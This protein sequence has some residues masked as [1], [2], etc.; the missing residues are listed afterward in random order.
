MIIQ[1]KRGSGLVEVVVVVSILTIVCLA[2][3]NSFIGLSGLHKK[4]TLLIKG[5][6]LTEEGVEIIRLVRD[7]GWVNISSIP[8]EQDRYFNLSLSAWG[9]TTTPE[10]ID[11]VFLRKFRLHE[12]RRVSANGAIVSSGGVVDTDTF[13]ADVSV[14]WLWNKA[15]TTLKYQSYVIRP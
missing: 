9:V 11:G 1:R 13:L 4:N 15:T 10:V 8:T 2:F 12:V 5:Q 3:L 14:S 7:S 6:L